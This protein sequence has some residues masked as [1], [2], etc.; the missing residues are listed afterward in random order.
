M[1]ATHITLRGRL[2]D[3]FT[4]ATLRG[5]S[6]ARFG[7]VRWILAAEKL[8]AE[9]GGLHVLLADGKLQIYTRRSDGSVS[10]S[11]W[12]PGEYTFEGR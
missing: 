3:C 8:A 4:P 9:I 12:K 7:G 10:V 11:T 5:I 6:R 2:S 1:R